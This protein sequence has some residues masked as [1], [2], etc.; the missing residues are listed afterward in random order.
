[1]HFVIIGNGITG[2]T[3]ARWIRKLSDHDVTVISSESQYFYSRTALMYIYMGHMTF[4]DTQPYEEGFWSKNRIQLLQDHVDSIDF[5]N[6]TLSLKDNGAISYDKLLIAVGSKPNYFGWPGQDLEGVSGL[7]SLQDLAYIEEKSRQLDRAVIVGGGLIG[8]EL[9]EM[10]HSR[11]IPVTMIVREDQYWDNVL[12][13]E[14]AKMISHHIRSHGIDLKLGLN[15]GQ[16]IGNEEGHACAVI[17]KETGE[18]ID[19]EF[20]GLTAGVHPNID[21]LRNSGLKVNRGILVDNTLKTNM[22]D[23]Y[24]AGDCAEL[25]ESMPGRKSIEAVWYTG[26]MMG[27]VTAYNI[28]GHAQAYDPG[29][30][31]NSAKFF[32]IEY[33]VYG[34]VLPK[35]P[36]SHK[37]LF[38]QNKKADKSIRIVY[39]S[40]NRAVLGFN[41][42]GIRFRHEVCDKWIAEKTNIEEVLCNLSLADFNPEFFAIYENELV[43]M[44]NKQ[45]GSQLKLKSKRSLNRVLSFLKSKA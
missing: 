7:Y 16:I 5:D 35:A 24:A 19:C 29:I 40:N 30:W 45:T 25:I 14:E 12:P 32:D 3:A 10:F 31:F 15:L 23:V 27:E 39:D 4:K 28:C 22:P 18:K 37:S 2:I 21:F 20:V 1:M 36:D 26:R 42:L 8:V 38:W 34:T 6:K 33:Q 41:L 9:A 13:H 11:G 17:V 43:H 44:Y